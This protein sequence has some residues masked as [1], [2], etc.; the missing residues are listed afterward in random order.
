VDDIDEEEIARQMSIIDWNLYTVIRPNEFL[1]K[2]WTRNVSRA[3][4]LIALQKRFNDV[5]KWVATCILNDRKVAGKGKAKSL[6]RF[7]R[8][9]DY[10]RNLNNFLSLGAIYTGIANTAVYNLKG[11]TREL[12]KQQLETL[13]ELERLFSCEGSYKNYR[14]AYN[15]AKPPCIPFIGVHLRD[16]SIVEDCDMDKIKGTINFSKRLVLYRIIT[17]T[18]RYQPIPYPYYTVHQVAVFLQGFNLESDKS[19]YD[20]GVLLNTEDVN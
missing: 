9:A 16:I 1:L 6:T 18:L 17:T 10:L 5:A 13:H 2:S 11:L 15:A 3:P 14:T 12:N 4:N 7:L 19:I 20:R 8:V